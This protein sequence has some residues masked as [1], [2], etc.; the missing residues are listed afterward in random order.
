MKKLFFKISVLTLVTSFCFASSIFKSTPFYDSAPNS[1][2]ISRVNLWPL[3]YYQK[4][5]WSILWPMIDKRDDGHAF[6]PLYSTYGY[7][8]ELNVLW[9]LANFN[10]LHKEYRIA[11]VYY[12]KPDE[13]FI[14]PLAY[15]NFEN[16]E[17]IVLNTIYDNNIFI[18]FPMYFYE[19]DK[20]WLVSLLAGKGKD[21]YS[22]MPPLWISSYN[23]TNDNFYFFA[24][25]GIYN[26]KNKD[27]HKFFALF[28]LIDYKK[29]KDYR[30]F[31]FFPIIHLYSS[32]NSKERVFFP[33][34]FSEK[35]KK[36]DFQLLIP[37]FYKDNKEK[38]LITPVF[39][40]LYDDKIKSLITPLISYKK[41]GDNNFVNIMG[42]IYNQTENK[43][44][45]YG[46]TDIIWPVFNYTHKKDKKSISVFPIF[47]KSSGSNENS[48]I[49][50]VFA[51]INDKNGE[52]IL[53]PLV[54]F[55]RRKKAKFINLLGIGYNRFVNT[56]KNY[57]RTDIIWPLFNH[58]YNKGKTKTYLFPLF[59]LNRLTNQFEFFS[60]V[61]SFGKNR[62]SGNKFI[63]IA[64]IIFHYGKTEKYVKGSVFWPLY[65]YTFYKN[66]SANH[67][68]LF[69][70][71]ERDK[72]IYKRSIYDGAVN[73]NETITQKFARVFIFDNF[74]S[75]VRC[76]S[77]YLPVPKALQDTNGILCE[78]KIKE[79]PEIWQKYAK[80]NWWRQKYL[81]MKIPLIYS[82]KWYEKERAHFDILYWLYES[83]WTAKSKNKPEKISRKFLWRIMNYNRAGNK[84][85]LDV[86][87]FITYDKAPEKE[88]TQFSFFWRLFR[89]RT[90]KEKR[91]L[92]ILFIPIR[93]EKNQTRL[94]R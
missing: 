68:M 40:M 75:G 78:S 89:W 73:D 3:Y 58:T 50:P 34:Y 22:V 55:G 1:R 54:S 91:A 52:E 25:L 6:R 15:L 63:N 62:H 86:F 60:P 26:S 17:F 24:P 71:I 23:R 47:Y 81:T 30:E 7:G 5:D 36:K 67:S 19:K 59:R 27:E 82:Y 56:E 31:S 8:N 70:F 92:D 88:I 57:N 69:D 49:T 94:P 18:F 66:G 38:L 51:S 74:K 42:L 11:N 64:G 79:H 41:G 43:K 84:I 20:F 83:D 2:K 87:P 29:E 93:W 21:W 9:P 28:K 46:K 35:N 39:G 37:F 10:F 85:A 65:E 77:N 32:S 44:K 13:L 90:E 33:L 45:G 14:F 12:D 53:T 48:I 76:K 61:V 16:K 80:K 4:P 72:N